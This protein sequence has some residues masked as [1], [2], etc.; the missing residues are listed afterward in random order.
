MSRSTVPARW[1]ATIVE[2]P[3]SVASEPVPLLVEHF[4]SRLAWQPGESRLSRIGPYGEPT[5]GA[6]Y[7]LGHGGESLMFERSVD[8]PSDETIEWGDRRRVEGYF[9]LDLASGTTEQ[10][11]FESVQGM[12]AYAD[13]ALSPDGCRAAI[14][15]TWLPP[16]LTERR[17]LPSDYRTRVT[18]AAFGGTDARVVLA[19]SGLLG[20]FPEST[21]MQWSPDGSWLAVTVAIAV[22]DEIARVEVALLDTSTGLIERRIK[23]ANLAG[24]SSWSPDGRS[25]LVVDSYGRPSIIELPSGERRPIPALP[26]EV[27]N[28]HERHRPRPLGWADNTRL[29]VGLTRGNTS[30]LCL[31][32]LDAGLQDT[33]LRWTGHY[34]D[35]VALAPMPLGFWV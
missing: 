10:A 4:G 31:F 7:V 28:A 29:I 5:G 11:R 1:T 30:R 3:L 27:A 24:T 23:D 14:A 17:I 13:F 20:W 26:D 12:K 8:D 25:L 6:A 2:E 9:R 15:Q 35:Y 22:P 34:Q 33:L 19:R 21:P 18:L 32:D 16:V